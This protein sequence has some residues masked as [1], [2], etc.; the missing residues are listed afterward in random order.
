MGIFTRFRDIVNS[1]INALLDKAEDP[2]KM[3]RLMMQEMEDTL[4]DLKSSC[5]AKIASKA[6][7][8]REQDVYQKKVALWTDRAQLAVEKGRDDLA[9]EAL[10]EKKDALSGLNELNKELDRLN[11]IIDE[12]KNNII[13]IEEKLQVVIQ[14]HKTLMRRGL[15]AKEK[16]KINKVVNDASGSGVITRFNNLENRIDRMESEADVSGFGSA[17]LESEFSKL[18]AGDDVDDELAELKKTVNKKK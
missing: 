3:I 1:N 4:V 14:K 2:E 6:R 18:E 16:V 8:V 17:S 5:A 9:K 7:T 13:L 11:Q 10:I 15:E 12:C